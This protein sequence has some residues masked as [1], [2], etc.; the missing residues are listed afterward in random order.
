MAIA[1]R[2]ARVSALLLTLAA[3]GGGA[4][5][6][7]SAAPA[8]PAIVTVDLDGLRAWLAAHRGAPLLV[9]FWA[10]WCAP[11]VAE[12]PDLMAGTREFRAAGGVVAAVALEC[13]VDDVTPTQ[14]EEKVRAKAAQLGLDCHVLVCTADDLLALRRALGVE[15]GALPQTVTFGPDGAVRAQHEGKASAAEFAALADGAR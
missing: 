8:A 14:A 7:A 4:P 6:G 15:L 9:N 1:E 10:T 2:G 12:L 3:C 5:S 11:C 13:V